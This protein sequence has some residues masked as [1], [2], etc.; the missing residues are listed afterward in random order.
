MNAQPAV[1]VNPPQPQ[2]QGA[3]AQAQGQQGRRRRGRQ[4]RAAPPPPYAPPAAVDNP[5]GVVYVHRPPPPPPAPKDDALSALEAALS[6]VEDP[7][8]HNVDLEQEWTCQEAGFYEL[9]DSTY[10]EMIKIDRQASVMLSPAEFVHAV[11][12]INV[13]TN[14]YA[15][16]TRSG[17]FNV[18]EAR[19]LLQLVE[20]LPAPK[21]FAPFFEGKGRIVESD[22]EVYQYVF[23]PGEFS[24]ADQISLAATSQMVAADQANLLPI[25]GPA[26]GPPYNTTPPGDRRRYNRPW[27]YNPPLNG[28]LSHWVSTATLQSYRRFMDHFEGRFSMYEMHFPHFGTIPKSAHSSLLLTTQGQ[29]NGGIETRYF[30]KHDGIE[31]V[32][33]VIFLPHE[34]PYPRGATGL[35]MLPNRLR[36][37]F[38]QVVRSGNIV[39][40]QNII[41]RYT[42]SFWK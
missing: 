3:Q 5:A 6:L 15:S 16:G 28:T 26:L 29:P 4:Q 37:G 8:T 22:G 35:H 27:N 17:T 25:V 1:P 11:S 7:F 31:M 34:L 24:A 2:A 40:R 19:D 33:G 36:A 32:R 41:G 10:D 42:S 9:A 18:P 23:R 21:S 39:N 38:A 30:R 12:V 13:A 14:Y 20:G